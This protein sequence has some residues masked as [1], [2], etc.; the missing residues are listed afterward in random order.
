MRASEENKRYKDLLLFQSVHGTT[1]FCMEEH[2][3]N[4]LDCLRSNR[5]QKHYKFLSRDILHIDMEVAEA[6][7]ERLRLASNF[8][9]EMEFGP[10]RF[11]MEPW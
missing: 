7:E 3:P 11:G 4:Q 9:V 6:V 2:R 10:S 1:I 5:L 8:A